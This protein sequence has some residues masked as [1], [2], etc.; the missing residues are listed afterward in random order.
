[1]CSFDSYNKGE[2]PIRKKNRFAVIIPVYNH[3]P[4]VENVIAKTL[5][6]G[7]PLFVVDDGSTDDTHER[8]RRFKDIHILRHSQNTGKGAAIMTGFLE[9]S[10]I[11]NWAITLDADGQH[12]PQDAKRLVQAAEKGRR[13]II[14]GRRIGMEGA[15]VHWTSRFG[16]KFSNFWVRVSGGPWMSDSQSGFRIY[17]LPEA[18]QWGVKSRRFEFEVEVLVRAH[19]EKT[20]V[21]EVPVNVSYLPPRERI[22]HFRPW[23]D[24]L[25]NAK[26]F[27][28]LIVLRFFIKLGS[29]PS[30]Y[31]SKE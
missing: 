14:V 3:G 29:L 2:I 15:N 27:T 1:M 5:G 12:N 31:K 23:M 18:I 19:W 16:R 10:R 25:R 22:S 17:P 20:P 30:V 24:F 13:A 21:I 26:T 4:A 6:L 7:L 11:A 9:A 28:R 8:I